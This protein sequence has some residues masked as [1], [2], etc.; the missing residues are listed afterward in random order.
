MIRYRNWTEN[1]RKSSQCLKKNFKR[2]SESLKSDGS[3]P[4]LKNKAKNKEKN[5]S[6]PLHNA[7][8]DM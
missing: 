5:N 4:V 3:R 7:V 2:S 8:C 1:E 6:G